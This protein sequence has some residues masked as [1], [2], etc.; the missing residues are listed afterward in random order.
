MTKYLVEPS[1]MFVWLD[2]IFGLFIRE[3]A[4]KIIGN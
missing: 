4:R 3:T 1:K 2:E